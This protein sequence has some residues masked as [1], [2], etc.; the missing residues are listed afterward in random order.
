[1]GIGAARSAPAPRYEPDSCGGRLGARSPIEPHGGFDHRDTRSPSNHSPTSSCANR[2]HGGFSYFLT[3][4]SL[5]LPRQ[6]HEVGARHERTLAAPARHVDYTS[7]PRPEDRHESPT[8]LS[9]AS[10]RRA[11]RQ[12]APLFTTSLHLPTRMST[13]DHV[14]PRRIT[15]SHVSPLRSIRHHAAPR[16]SPSPH[17]PPR[18]ATR[19]PPTALTNPNLRNPHD[20]RRI[21]TIVRHAGRSPSARD[22]AGQAAG[23]AGTTDHLHFASS[24]PAGGEALGR[25][26]RCLPADRGRVETDARWPRIP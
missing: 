20:R 7:A 12:D 6:R 15:P 23:N 13:F 24:A 22:R 10:P 2:S 4:S 11:T 9:R 19:H 1:M 26:L 25:V 18:V 3:T 16:T 21:A 5:R 17:F 14:S 8:W